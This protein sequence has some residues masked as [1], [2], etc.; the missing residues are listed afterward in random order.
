MS[1]KTSRYSILVLSSC[2]AVLTLAA[3]DVPNA[4]PRGYGYHDE[5]YKSPNPPES[6]KFT[7]LLRQSM[8]PEQ[9]DQ[10]RMAVYTLVDNLTNRAGMPPK[11]VYVVKP[12]PMTPF[13]ANLDNDLRE[14]LRHVGYRLADSPDDSYAFTYAAEIL[15]K[16]GAPAGDMSPNVRLTLYVHDKVGDE[17]RVLT[18]ESGEFY[19]QGAEALSVPFASFPGT[20]V[21]EPT[22]PGENFRE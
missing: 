16:E 11:A 13:Y 18:Q 15:N 4:M 14:S 3:C 21:P 5:V 12:E 19:I 20:F 22:G 6:S 2:A 10:F 17:G 7:T 1:F 8:G 9:A